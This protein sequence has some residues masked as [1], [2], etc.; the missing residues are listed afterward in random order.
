MSTWQ[1][2]ETAP[3]SY[4][5]VIVAEPVNAPDEPLRY[6]VG[7]ARYI[8]GE[9]WYW[10]NCDPSDSWGRQLFP[11]HWMPLPAPPEVTK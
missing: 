9:G 7:E 6:A 11:S 3:P 1:P 2:I 8:D 5:F 4:T 10:V